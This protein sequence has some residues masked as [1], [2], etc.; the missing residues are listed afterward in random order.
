M[1]ADISMFRQQHIDVPLEETEVHHELGTL[2]TAFS[3]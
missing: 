1:E 2:T 3:I